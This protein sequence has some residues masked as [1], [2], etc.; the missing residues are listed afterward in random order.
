MTEKHLTLSVDNDVA[1]A[2]FD[3]GAP[4]T[5]SQI[6]IVTSKCGKTVEVPFPEIVEQVNKAKTYNDFM[7]EIKSW[8]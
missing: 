1:N 5:I 8:F 3:I 6:S 7:A 4:D 2:D